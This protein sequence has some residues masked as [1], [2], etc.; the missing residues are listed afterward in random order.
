MINESAVSGKARKVQQ[1]GVNHD[2]Y[3]NDNDDENTHRGM[4]CALCKRKL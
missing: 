2:D 4:C 3:N 1:M